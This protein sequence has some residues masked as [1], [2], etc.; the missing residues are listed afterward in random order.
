MSENIFQNNYSLGSGCI[1]GCSWLRS[2][3]S[4]AWRMAKTD[5][6][7][8]RRQNLYQETASFPWMRKLFV[9][10]QQNTVSVSRV[11]TGSV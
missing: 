1:V 6:V 10:Q 11:N 8:W 3:V 4:K 2:V 5:G 7:Y 9:V